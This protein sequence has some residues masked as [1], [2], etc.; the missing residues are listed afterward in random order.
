MSAMADKFQMRNYLD[1]ALTEG[2]KDKHKLGAVR[3]VLSMQPAEFDEYRIDESAA[4][5]V[6]YCLKELRAIVAFA[7]AFALPLTATFDGGGK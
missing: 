4:G 7:E 5:P 6:T 2:T 3:T 1:P